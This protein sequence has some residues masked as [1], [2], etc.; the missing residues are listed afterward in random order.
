M[1]NRP[2][3]PITEDAKIF[4]GRNAYSARI[5]CPTCE[6]TARHDGQTCGR[7]AGYG[8]M[9][10]KPEL[11]TEADQAAVEAQAVKAEKEEAHRAACRAAGER[12]RARLANSTV[13]TPGPALAA[14]PEAT[15]RGIGSMMEEEDAHEY[16][17]EY[18]VA[19]AVN[20]TPSLDAVKE[21]GSVY[22]AT[23][24]Q[25]AT[26]RAV[27]SDLRDL[28][29]AV[30]RDGAE[31]TLRPPYP[32][33]DDRRAALTASNDAILAEEAEKAVVNYA[34]E[35][36]TVAELEALPV[37]MVVFSPD[38]RD[39]TVARWSD[40][41]VPAGNARCLVAGEGV[42]VSGF[43][44]W[45]DLYRVALL[46]P[47]EPAEKNTADDVAE[48][49]A[50]LEAL[51]TKKDDSPRVYSWRQ[52]EKTGRADLVGMICDACFGTQSRVADCFRCEGHG[53]VWLT[54]PALEAKAA[55]VEERRNAPVTDP[56][57]LDDDAPSADRARIWDEA[58]SAYRRAFGLT[59]GFPLDN[60]YRAAAE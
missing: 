55:S 49:V 59:A 39:F 28:V 17:L 36:R 6:G 8:Y 46:T 22:A 57:D 5:M 56:T 11:R 21:G 15:R 20:G 19:I 40:H 1:S 24:E 43:E 23:P 18:A 29:D 7:C 53:V 32:L 51:P 50:E 12:R 27:L 13:G 52:A 37:G 16:T 30:G 35:A 48:F 34:T 14:L 2:V 41:V 9:W 60:P 42:S 58:A 38:G 45:L 4:S 26:A 31:L 44:A 3:T 33:D 54:P 47:P 25:E 10:E